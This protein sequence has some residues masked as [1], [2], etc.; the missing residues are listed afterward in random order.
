MPDDSNRTPEPPVRAERLRQWL[1]NFWPS[2]SHV[3]G[4][5][6]LRMVVGVGLTLLLTGLVSRWWGQSH[7]APWLF[8][9]MGASALLL[10]CTPSSPMAQPWPVIG[11]SVFSG[12]A[13]LGAALVIDDPSAAAAVS[14]GLAVMVMV[15]M[16]CLHPPGAAL[17]MWIA[18]EHGTDVSVLAYPVATN[19]V[20][21][22]VLATL[23]SRA[24]GKRYPAPQH[25]QKPAAAGDARNMRI[26][27]VDLDAALDH[28]NGVLDVSRADLEAL[29]HMASQAAFKRT[30][31]DLRCE[32]IMVHPVFVTTAD[33]PVQQAWERMQQHDVKALPVVDEKMQ[34]KG[35][36]TSTD[37][38]NQALSQ[39]PAGLGDRLKSLVLRKKKAAVVVGE[40]MTEEV[41]TV[42]G[43]DRV[44]DL[45]AVFSRGHLRHL[46]V[47][48]AQGKLVG[49]VTQTDLIRVMA[50]SLASAHTTQALQKA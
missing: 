48:N 22:V 37:L 9:A 32:D 31:G 36:I 5:E 27:G 26:E 43:Y 15:V 34:V 16:R 10:V 45:I 49:M 6:L 7:H 14:A 29:V 24:T 39:A 13:G 20:L 8:A 25:S 33:A 23:Y 2:S 19:L 47:I 30:L 41:A 18:L 28:F 46:P 21:L 1:R 42:Q 38:L 50:K 17:A 40:L 4:K 3:N 11:G 35:I 12:L 44:V